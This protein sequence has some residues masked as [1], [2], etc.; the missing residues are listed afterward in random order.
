MAGNKSVDA[1]DAEEEQERAQRKIGMCIKQEHS[2]RGHGRAE[3]AGSRVMDFYHIEIL[4]I[5]ASS[6][7]SAPLRWVLIYCTKH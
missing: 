5:S 4:F 7:S 1:E 6:A 3:T 2:W